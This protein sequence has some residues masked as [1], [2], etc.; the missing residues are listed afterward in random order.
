MSDHSMGLLGG[1]GGA[2]AGHGGEGHKGNATP[3][4]LF[5][6]WYKLCIQNK[7]TIFTYKCDLK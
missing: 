2:G 6:L 4:W 7:Y 5:K 3:V 1:G